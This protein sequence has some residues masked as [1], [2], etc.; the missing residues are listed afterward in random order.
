MYFFFFYFTFLLKFLFFLT[1]LFL[2]L[3]FC[4]I[5]FCIQFFL[6]LLLLHIDLLCFLWCC[7]RRYC[8]SKIV[9]Q[10][11]THNRA[12]HT[13]NAR[14]PSTERTKKWRRRN[15]VHPKHTQS[16]LKT[17]HVCKSEHLALLLVGRLAGWLVRS[18]SSWL[19]APRRL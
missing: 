13:L 10:L 9:S 4:T 2:H 8:C 12:T 11:G 6:L 15:I 1:F 5:A 19:C 7:C 16:K 14:R 17:R 18:V 3:N